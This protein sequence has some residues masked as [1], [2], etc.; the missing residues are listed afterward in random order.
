MHALCMYLKVYVCM[1][2]QYV[3]T[4]GTYIH[5]YV[6]CECTFTTYVCMYV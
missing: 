2:V 6:E 3:A 4:I 1:Y 5:M